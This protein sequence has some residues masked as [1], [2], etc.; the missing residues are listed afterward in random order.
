MNPPNAAATQSDDVVV[1]GEI[2][3]MFGTQDDLHRD[4][5]QPHFLPPM[6][7]SS[8]G[9]LPSA[10]QIPF[11]IGLEFIEDDESGAGIKEWVGTSLQ[12]GLFYI[13][14]GPMESHI[15]V[16][17]GFV[18]IPLTLLSTLLLFG[19]RKVKRIL[20]PAGY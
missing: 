8:A 6:I 16:P 19:R 15:V 14:H 9:L 1:S 2:P 11:K 10:V 17:Y 12:W 3:E 20:A 5:Q 18:V 13:S 7:Q 4:L